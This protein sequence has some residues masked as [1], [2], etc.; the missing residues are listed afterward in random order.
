MNGVNLLGLGKLMKD[1]PVGSNLTLLN[2]VYHKPYFDESAKSGQGKWMNGSI[3]IVFYDNDTGEKKVYQ[4]ED[5]LFTFFKCKPE[6]SKPY[7]RLFIAKEEATPVECRYK[8]VVKQIAI[9]TG[10]MNFY[11]E[12]M[13]AQNK[14]A[15]NVL[16]NHPDIFL[17]DMHIE[18]Y[19]KLWFSDCY[20]NDIIPVS[21]CF[22]D[23]EADTI[24]MIG[25]FPEMGECPINAVTLVFKKNN[26]VL[27]LLLRDPE[28]PLIDEFER[29]VQTGEVFP[30][31][32]E[33]IKDAVG[34]QKK[35]EA[36]EL[37][38]YEY[39]IIF[40]DSDKEINLILDI[41]SSI[42]YYKPDFA[43]AWNAAFDL[44]YI[45]A[46][47]Q[48]LGYDPTEIMCHP[49][50]FRKEA[51]YYI[52]EMRKSEFAERGDYACISSY[53]VFLDQMIH[54]ASRRKGRG[55]FNSFGLDYIGNKVTG[56]R[57]LDYKEIT[58]NISELP[59]KN[60]KVFAFYNIFDTIVQNC[61]ESKTQDLEYIFG[62]C[63]VNNTRYNKC[64]RQTVYLT[65]RGAKEFLEQ[66]FIIGNNANRNTS[67]PLTKFPGAF[68]AD[69][70]KTNDYSK[71]KIDGHPVNLYDNLD[72]F[73][74][75][76]LYP[77]IIRE[78]NIA[79]NTQVGMLQIPEKVHCKENRLNDSQWSRAGSF[80]EDM[81]SNVWL[82]FAHR[83]FGLANYAELYSDIEEFFLNIRMPYNCLR[84]YDID[85]L[86]NP[87]EVYNN[88]NILPYIIPEKNNDLINPIQEFHIF[89]KDL[90]M[91]I[92]Y[93][94]T[95][96]PNQA[97][98][99]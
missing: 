29:Q 38:K 14:R 92:M 20:Q 32:K 15:N 69:P 65:N 12:N 24:N 88:D 71:K 56:V 90:G 55:T 5:P 84:K 49:D 70:T 50:F 8:D 86:I 48:K 16:H 97:F 96:N 51:Y 10:N 58:T 21:K 91:E 33:F 78:F 42:N 72:D 64:H 40:Y 17:S 81:Q 6:F 13:S 60:Y 77:S 74:Y 89:P 11:S 3:E 54:F 19:Y 59:R 34:G 73:D 99:N 22:F 76:S 7:T 23:I 63:N 39:D 4:E 52:D 80:M 41:F 57:K 85:G 31:L 95:A 98:G 18:D 94:A 9:E 45:I 68:V 28:N 93:N 79:A 25:D 47:I 67:A 82:E 66:G 46:R 83:W 30:E 37:D 36:Y 27:T 26:K 1:Y 2:V 87:I 35:L 43:E 44:P 62:K 61:I 75:K 53:T